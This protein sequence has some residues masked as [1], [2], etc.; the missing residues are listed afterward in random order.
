MG[1]VK[2]GWEL[3]PFIVVGP[4]LVVAYNAE[5]FGGLIHTDIGFAVAWGA[6]PVL[7]AYVAKIEV[8]R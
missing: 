3:V 8:W 2:V 4:L 7:T 5:M 1:V 6:F